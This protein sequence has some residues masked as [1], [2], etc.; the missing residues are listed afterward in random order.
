M[1][2]RLGEL[3]RVGFRSS[4]VR[5]SSSVLL[6]RMAGVVFTFLVSLVLARL[7]GPSVTGAYYLGAMVVTVWSALGR[8]GLDNALMRFAAAQAPRDRW[9]AV[10]GLRRAG[11][12]TAGATALVLAVLAWLLAPWLATS[13][14]RQP[15]VAPYLRTMS[16]AILPMTLLSVNSGL[17]KAIKRPGLAVIADGTTAPLLLT[18]GLVALAPALGPQA[19]PV[20]YVVA[21]SMA[22][23]VGLLL[24]RHTT[25]KHRTP[26]DRVAISAI[27][28]VAL[29]MVSITFSGLLMQWTDTFM[30]GIWTTTEQVGIYAVALRTALLTSFVH[31][32]INAVVAPE[33]SDMHARSDLAGIQRL[34]S[35]SASAM[36]AIA[37]PIVLVFLL[38]PRWVLATLFGAAFSGG[39]LALAILSIGQFVNVA[40][41]SV[42]L[43]LLMTGNERTVQRIVLGTAAANLG[44]NALLIPSQ[45]VV[46]AAIATATS[47]C[48]A[49]VLYA[50]MAYRRLTVIALPFW[51]KKADP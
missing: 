19:P 12:G 24:W 14:F 25:S 45:G 36:V 43:L 3:L 38:V 37:L 32:T 9:G 51:R 46:G 20:V 34:A 39:S 23:V 42:A 27:L 26:P 49:N 18:V 28:G 35:A 22:L 2:G 29:P 44:L 13:I 11:L 16:V 41:G 15:S 6:L 4:L 50:V 30:L 47:T 48:I 5:R 40:T 10:F 7:F 8:L 17:L 33:F 1:N 31:T 21:Y